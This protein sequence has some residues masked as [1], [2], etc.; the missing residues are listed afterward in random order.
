MTKT[1]SVVPTPTSALLNKQLRT[2]G[3]STTNF[4]ASSVGVKFRNGM[5]APGLNM[6]AWVFKELTMAQI[7]GTT[8][9]TAARHS[10]TITNSFDYHIEF[11]QSRFSVPSYGH[12]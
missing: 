7:N 1:N 5:M 10:F 6:S 2:C 12:Y 9:Q 8:T 11:S 3:S 4:H